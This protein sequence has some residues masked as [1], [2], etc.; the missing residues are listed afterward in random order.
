MGVWQ[1]CIYC[2]MI[3][4]HFSQQRRPEVCQLHPDR[5]TRIAMGYSTFVAGRSIPAL[6]D[7]CSWGNDDRTMVPLTIKQ[8]DLSVLSPT[9]T[10]FLLLPPQPRDRTLLLAV[11]DRGEQNRTL[12]PRTRNPNADPRTLRPGG[13]PVSKELLMMFHSLPSSPTS[14]HLSHLDQVYDSSTFSSRL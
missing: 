9:A 11:D 6:E 3:L 12:T 5:G 4:Y 13:L 10:G 8:E 1:M 14:P 2:P 7:S